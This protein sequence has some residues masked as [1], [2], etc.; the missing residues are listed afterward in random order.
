MLIREAQAE[1]NESICRLLSLLFEQEAEFAPDAAAQSKGIGEILSAPEK[2]RFFVLEDAGRIVGCVSLL[3][4]VSTALGGTAAVL[5]DLVLAE[6]FRG[7][8]WGIQLL[9]F[10]IDYAARIGCKRLTVLTDRDNLA[11]QSL[12]RK[13]G[14]T[15]SEMIPMRLVF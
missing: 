11:A 12:Y 7:R 14:F 5:E 3:F 4:V 6:A 15:V 8:G 13:M 1:D 9:E 2:G 10:A